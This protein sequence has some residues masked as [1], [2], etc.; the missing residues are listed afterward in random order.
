MAAAGPR[1]PL[2]WQVQYTEPP[3]GAAAHV[4]AAGPPRLPFAWQAQHTEPFAGGAVRV[5]AAGP[6]LPFAWQAEKVA[7]SF[8][9]CGFQKLD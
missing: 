1:L 8:S 7:K 9:F 4:A 2:A 3:G 5:A 6:R